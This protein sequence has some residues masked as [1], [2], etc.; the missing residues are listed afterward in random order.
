M[1]TV[2]SP[3]EK[4]KECR[5]CSGE[6]VSHLGLA[7]RAEEIRLG[8][9]TFESGRGKREGGLSLVETKP[10]KI[11]ERGEKGGAIQRPNWIRERRQLVSCCA[12][13]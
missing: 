7:T 6:G 4:K 11:L 2:L 10:R 1:E 8:L 9:N 12:R 13:D 5:N 3:K